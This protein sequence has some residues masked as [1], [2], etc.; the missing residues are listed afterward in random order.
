MGSLGWSFLIWSTR[1][2]DSTH[3]IECNGFIPKTNSSISLHRLT[4]KHHDSSSIR[5]LSPKIIALFQYSSSSFA[6]A[7]RH[8]WMIVELIGNYY[9]LIR[10]QQSGEGSSITHP[11]STADLSN[12]RCNRIFL[13]N[14]FAS[15]QFNQRTQHNSHMTCDADCGYRTQKPVAVWSSRTTHNQHQQS[16]TCTSARSSCCLPDL[17]G[18]GI[19]ARWA[20]FDW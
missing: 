9:P 8:K 7:F 13:N 2:N 11:D 5:Y 12:E 17:H 19:I 3:S 6:A 10:V 14:S 18:N 20:L 4:T 16:S 1:I 15:L